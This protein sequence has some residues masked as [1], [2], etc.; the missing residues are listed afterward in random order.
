MGSATCA[1]SMRGRI[2]D[3]LRTTAWERIAPLACGRKRRRPP[4]E[5]GSLYARTRGRRNRR[6]S[7]SFLR[8]HAL[9]RSALSQDRVDALDQLPRAER[10]GDVVVGADF[11]PDLLVHVAAL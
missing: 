1:K 6:R 3:R 7:R 8:L 11:E 2:L 5:T 9:G 4:R 10:L